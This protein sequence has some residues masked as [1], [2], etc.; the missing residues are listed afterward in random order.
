VRHAL[1]ITARPLG[2]RRQGANADCTCGQWTRFTNDK[3]PAQARLRGWSVTA[4]I[5]HVATTTVDSD[6]AALKLL[7][8]KAQ[9]R[10]SKAV[11]NDDAMM[12]EGWA[13]VLA[14]LHAQL[15]A[16]LRLRSKSPTKPA[17]AARHYLATAVQYEVG[18]VANMPDDEALAIATGAGWK[19]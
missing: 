5:D 2:G 14:D 6:I 11:E 18:E 19:A 4:H 15:A 9:T 12:L 13:P 8:A 3:T 10:V 17:D 16:D 1:T 7:I